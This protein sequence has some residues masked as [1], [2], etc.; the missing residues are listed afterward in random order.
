MPSATAVTPLSG[1]RR[2]DLTSLGMHRREGSALPKSVE[3]GNLSLNKAV[4]R[5]TSGGG[6]GG[7][8]PQP[9]TS[10]RR[11]AGREKVFA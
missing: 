3:R 1:T 5:W 2:V 4:I 6:R 7:A 9:C 8:S 11:V 10:P